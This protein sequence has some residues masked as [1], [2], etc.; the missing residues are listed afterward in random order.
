MSNFC[1]ITLCNPNDTTKT[2]VLEFK[3]FPVDIVDRW[4]QCILTAKSKSYQIDDPNRFYGMN[5]LVCDQKFALEKINN[6]IDVINNFEPIIDRKLLSLDDQDT[7]NYL[8]HVFEIYHGLLDQ[9]THELWERSPT[10]VRK[11]LAELNIAVHRVESTYRN[12]NPRFVVTYFGLPKTCKL[13]QEDFNY[14]TNCFNFGGLYLNYVEI[15][16]TLSD[17]VNDD[18]QYIDPV[19]FKPWDYF[20]ADFNVKLFNSD[21]VKAKNHLTDCKKYFE[22]HKSFFANLGYDRFSQQLHPGTIGLGQLIY[23]D[24]EKVLDQIRRHQYVLSVDF[25]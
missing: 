11:A 8:H 14:L 5:G 7:L 22:K 6:C 21:T 16:K 20:S 19:A 18:D 4:K 10:A 25:N 3:L 12:N 17:L 15:G 9:Q 13:H 24:R 23:S 1:Y 2:I